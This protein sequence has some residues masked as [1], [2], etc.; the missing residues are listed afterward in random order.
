MYK[1]VSPSSKHEHISHRA[2]QLQPAATSERGQR[3]NRR[4]PPAASLSRTTLFSLFS[5]PANPTSSSDRRG[6]PRS[7]NLGKEPSAKTCKQIA[8]TGSIS[9]SGKRNIKS[10]NSSSKQLWPSK[11]RRS[12]KFWIGG[13][14][15][16][17]RATNQRNTTIAAITSI[18]NLLLLWVTIICC[19]MRRI[20]V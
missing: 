1:S 9:N 11:L 15:I 20:V 17:L 4:Q 2:T 10:S 16:Y 7:S 19:A 6:P 13:R 14:R 8:P 5:F 3:C 18:F 12:P